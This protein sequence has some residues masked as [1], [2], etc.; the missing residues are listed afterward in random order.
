MRRRHGLKPRRGV[1]C[2]ASDRTSD[3][4]PYVGD[5]LTTLDTDADLK[6]EAELPSQ[7]RHRVAHLERSANRPERVVLVHGRNAEDT[8]DGIADE[9][10]YYPPVPL[11]RIAH[12]S[13]VAIEDTSKDLGVE[14]LS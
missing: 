14:T 5:G 10:F 6:V 1:E 11:D 7:H 12:R 13:V 9:L 4:G 8:Y 3:R 2:V